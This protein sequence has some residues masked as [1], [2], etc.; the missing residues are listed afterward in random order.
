MNM[1]SSS[2]H[3]KHRRHDLVLPHRYQLD[4]DYRCKRNCLG[5]SELHRC[6]YQDRKHLRFHPD[7]CPLGRSSRNAKESLKPFQQISSHSTNRN[8]R[9]VILSTHRARA[10]Q[11]LIR[12]TVQVPVTA[13][14]E[15][16]AG[17]SNLALATVSS[18]P[19]AATHCV[20]IAD[21]DS[22]SASSRNLNASAS[23]VGFDKA[24]HASALVRSFCVYANAIRSTFACS[25]TTFVD[26]IAL[27]SMELERLTIEWYRMES[28][29]AVIAFEARRH[30][31]ASNSR[32]ARSQRVALVDVDAINS[33]FTM[34]SRGAR[35][36]TEERRLI[37]RNALK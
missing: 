5:D 32:V 23:G 30:V 18:S 3:R 7:L 22:I 13:A 28:R 1:K 12:P 26:I 29:R 37:G 6:R 27:L 14:E 8:T 10:S 25:V 34:I 21:R 19:D 24:S 4:Q 31:G 15:S 33:V 16:V 36:A 11:V 9:T 2:S 17:K 20:L 35:L